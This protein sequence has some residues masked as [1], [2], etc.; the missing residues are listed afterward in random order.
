[1]LKKL[2]VGPLLP[3]GAAMAMKA[4]AAAAVGLAIRSRL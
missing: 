3:P 2:L 1:M 4:A